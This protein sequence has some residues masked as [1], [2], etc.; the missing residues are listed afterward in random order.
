MVI[1]EADQVLVESRLAAG[2]V[3][4]PVCPGVLAPR[5]CGWTQPSSSTLRWSRSSR[6]WSPRL[7]PA[8]PGGDRRLLAIP[9]DD[10][11]VPVLFG[12]EPTA[13]S[14]GIGVE[15]GGPPGRPR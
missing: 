7:A 13:Y 8:D 5:G 1:V 4:C 12:A 9:A 10:R 15:R 6:R 3:P 11:S 2:G 14:A